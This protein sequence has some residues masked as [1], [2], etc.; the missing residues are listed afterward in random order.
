MADRYRVRAKRWKNCRVSVARPQTSCLTLPLASRPLVSIRTSFG[1]VTAPGWPPARHPLRSKQSWIRLSR[2]PTS[3][4]LTIGLFC[5]GA[6]LAWRASRCVKNALS[7]TCADGREKRSRKIVVGGAYGRQQQRQDEAGYA[8]RSQSLLRT[9][10]PS[11]ETSYRV[12][13]V[14]L[15]RYRK[16]QARYCRGQQILA[17]RR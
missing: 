15:P 9:R 17:C 13:Q 7:A 1:S 4:M 3:A 12:A 16:F 8:R 6:T 5:T 14:W 10:R 11:S 2:R